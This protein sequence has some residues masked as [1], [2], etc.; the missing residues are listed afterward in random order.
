MSIR[1]RI[2]KLEDK[3]REHATGMCGWFFMECFP[4]RRLADGT[5]FRQGCG[6]HAATCPL[7]VDSGFRRLCQP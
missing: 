7:P 5:E 2:E 1:T 4:I 6:E 3:R